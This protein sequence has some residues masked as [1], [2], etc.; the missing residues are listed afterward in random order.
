MENILLQCEDILHDMRDG[1]E[2]LDLKSRELYEVSR[3]LEVY[4]GP[5]MVEFI[6]YPKSKGVLSF[7]VDEYDVIITGCM[8]ALGELPDLITD[9]ME[10]FTAF[11][12]EMHTKHLNETNKINLFIEKYGK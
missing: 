2:T 11:L 4:K 10:D 12:T 3:K 1:V 8:D 7:I 6:F 5:K 9:T